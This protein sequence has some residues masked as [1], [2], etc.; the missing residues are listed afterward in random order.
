MINLSILRRLAGL[1]S[2]GGL[3]GL[4]G[5]AGT[6]RRPDGPLEAAKPRLAAG[7]ASCDVARDR[8]AI[9]AMAGDYDVQFAF[10]ETAPLA[11]GYQ[12]KKPYRV[13][14]SEVVLV[15]ES[16][17]R[18]VVLQHI[19]TVNDDGKPE[20]M[21]HWRQDWSFEDQ[22]LLEYR[23]G[24]R[25]EK[26]ALAPGEAQCGWTQAVF[27]INDGPR[28]EG[29]GRFVHAA[30]SSTW[31]SNQTWRPLPRRER[32]REDYDVIVGINRHS[33][34]S[35][36]WVHEQDNTKMILRGAPHGLVRE[37]GL[38]VYTRSKE[39]DLTVARDYWKKH[40][41]FWRDVR[42]AWARVIDARTSLTFRSASGATSLFGDLA[43]LEEAAVTGDRTGRAEEVLVRHL[44][45]P[46]AGR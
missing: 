22:T 42:T 23:G 39:R 15:V 31:T 19:L 14:A 37:H 32:A 8:A 45:A 24:N 12:I 43:A 33:M 34:T 9:L 10:E 41:A 16:D 28:Y 6:E 38:N 11:A 25:W 29:W 20:A 46:I 26:R 21:K 36:G 44:E 4:V 1:V 2:V 18:H 40:E 35:S 3:L 13:G 27:E 30:G 7:V 5:C 17:E